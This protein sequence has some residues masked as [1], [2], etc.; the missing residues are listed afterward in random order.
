MP[1]HS[2]TSPRRYP[3]PQFEAGALPAPL[4]RSELHLDPF[5]QFD[6][7]MQSALQTH[8]PNATA[9][10]LATVDAQGR[11]HS[12]VVQLSAMQSQGFEFFTHY[13][14]DKAIHLQNCHHAALHFYWPQNHRQIRIEGMVEKLPAADSDATFE[15][16]QRDHQLAALVSQQSQPLPG[17]RTLEQ[18]IQIAD[19][20]HNHALKRPQ[21]WGGYRLIPD[22]FEFWQGRADFMHD[23][24]RYTPKGHQAWSV[25][26][27]SP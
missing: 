2:L 20:E 18:N 6:Q 26:R 22:C 8:I 13:E 4:D 25:T 27:L 12:R 5:V 14:S 16:L 10:S 21:H 7:W 23:R 9:M 11:P 24:F 1:H 3:Q 19:S 17:R 15:Q